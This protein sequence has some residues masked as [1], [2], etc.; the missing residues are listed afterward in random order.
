[1]R[2]VLISLGFVCVSFPGREEKTASSVMDATVVSV[3]F[4]Q[5]YGRV[6][7]K[8]FASGRLLLLCVFLGQRS[9]STRALRRPNL[10]A[11]LRDRRMTFARK[12]TRSCSNKEVDPSN[13]KTQWSINGVKGSGMVPP[14][15][16]LV[17]ANMERGL[18]RGPAEPFFC[19]VSNL[20]SPT[21]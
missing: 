5:G 12:N 4:G 19:F 20:F 15:C 9:D 18:A 13:R 8:D 21:A 7:G 10:A 16:P 17:G 3:S 11:V 1:M 6:K 2:V 14:P